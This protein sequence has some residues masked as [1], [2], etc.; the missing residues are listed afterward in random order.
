[1]WEPCSG[2]KLKKSIVVSDKRYNTLAGICGLDV[3]QLGVFKR[4]W[5]ICCTPPSWV[6]C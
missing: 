3:S 2:A 5:I 6:P 1:M 4:M